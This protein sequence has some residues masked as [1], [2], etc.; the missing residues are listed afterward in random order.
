MALFECA[1][2]IFARTCEPDLRLN[3]VA[4]RVDDP[5]SFHRLAYT[6][7]PV[8]AKRRKIIPNREILIYTVMLFRMGL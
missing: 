5:V 3:P 2:A 8:T 1:G 6:S 4:R 7:S